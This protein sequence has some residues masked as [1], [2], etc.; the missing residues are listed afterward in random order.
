MMS[1]HRTILPFGAALTL[2]V[3][4]AGCGKKAGND[5]AD[6]KRLMDTSRA[7]SRAASAGDMDAVLGYFADD[8][9]IIAEGQPPVRGKAAIRSYLA[10]SAKIPGFH[11]SWEPIEA[12]VSGDMG[13]LIERTQISM[14]G[15]QGTPVTQQL[16]AVTIWRKQPDGTWKAVVDASA[17]GP[18]PAPAATSG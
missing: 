3:L 11:I 4:L 15:P 18:P 14:N 5:E 2:A 8:A 17:S 6:A 13:Y 1:L 9:I 12:K 10:E 16:Q 7:W